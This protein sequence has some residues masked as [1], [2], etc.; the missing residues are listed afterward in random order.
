MGMGKFYKAMTLNRKKMVMMFKRFC[1]LTDH[2]ANAI[3]MYFGINS[4]A[5]LTEFLHDQWKD[6]FTQWQK[7]RPNQDSTEW[8]M[9]LSPPSARLY[10]MCRMGLSTQAP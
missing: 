5:H 10:M 7:R 4:K 2:D 9:V 6:T 8:V 1:D 3:V